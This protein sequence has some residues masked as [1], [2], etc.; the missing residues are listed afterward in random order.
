MSSPTIGVVVGADRLSAG[1]VDDGRVVVRDRVAPPVREVWR[2]LAALVERVLAAT[3]ENAQRPDRIGVSCS[4]PIDYRSGAA[5]PAGI[6]AW[7]GF[8]LGPRL[9][10][11][12]GLPT[13]IDS[14]AGAVL[15]AQLDND[16]GAAAQAAESG[17]LLVLLDAGVDGATVVGGRRLRGHHGNAGAIGHVTVD[18]DGL[19]C[20]C[21]ARGCLY[22]YVSAPALEAEINRPLQRATPATIER[23]GIMFGRAISDLAAMVDVGRVAVGGGVTT[24]FGSGFLDAARRELAA[25]APSAG[26]EVVPFDP[27][28]PSIVAAA[29]VADT[30][31]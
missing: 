7:N 17:M 1:L 23:A 14:S 3:P 20:P 29:A 24:T 13:Q 11:L 27:A 16:R 8:A 30:A 26:T 12:C 2:T 19:A 22:P 18:P 25:R 28:V 6:P 4:G 5:S 15:N 21:G 10:E 9:E 31:E